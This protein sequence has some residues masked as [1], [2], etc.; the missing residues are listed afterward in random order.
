MKIFFFN[1]HVLSFKCLLSFQNSVLLYNV[2]LYWSV[3]PDAALTNHYNLVPQE[4]SRNFFLHSSGG[5]KSEI[6]ITGTYE[7]V[8][9]AT[10]SLEPLGEIC[11]LPLPASAGCWHC[12]AGGCQHFSLCLHGHITF[13]SVC[14][15]S[16][17]HFTRI[18]VIAFMVHPENPG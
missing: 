12:L 1:L 2:L 9:R 17:L 8:I 16:C 10:L 6:S 18:H 14:Q 13:S 11:P 3:F 7:G 4:K 15:I 5:R